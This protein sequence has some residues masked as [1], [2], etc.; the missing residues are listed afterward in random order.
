MQTV[1]R[2]E[3]VA[4]PYEKLKALTRGRR[5]DA[6]SMQGILEE[7]PLSDDAR[8]RLAA[9]TPDSYLGLAV[10]LARGVNRTS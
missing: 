5:I 7:L 10:E 9:M 1:M 3:G 4:E 8:A 6:A 2:R